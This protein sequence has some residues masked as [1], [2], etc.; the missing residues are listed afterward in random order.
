MFDLPTV[1]HGLG[2][3]AHGLGT[4]AQGLAT[5][6]PVGRAASAVAGV[7]IELPFDDPNLTSIPPIYLLITLVGG[8]AVVLAALYF[9]KKKSGSD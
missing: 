5:A 2:T 9:W 7:T 8:T 4:A 1:V 3:A 6:A